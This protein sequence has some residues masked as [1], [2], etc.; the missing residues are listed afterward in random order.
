MSK[1]MEF[2]EL[3]VSKNGS[4]CTGTE[5]LRAGRWLEVRGWGMCLEAELAEQALLFFSFFKLLFNF[6]QL[7]LITLFFLPF[8]LS[9]S[10]FSSE[11]C[12]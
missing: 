7:F 1:G 2:V 9:F 6:L 11:W 3:C 8:F 12:G 4:V 10:L 5:S